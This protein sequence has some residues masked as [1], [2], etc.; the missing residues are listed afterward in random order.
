MLETQVESLGGGHDE[1]YGR[2]EAAGDPAQL[3]HF[4][5]CHVQMG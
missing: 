1:R 2:E 4:L 3:A 5:L